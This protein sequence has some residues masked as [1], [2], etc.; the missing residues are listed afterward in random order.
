MLTQ[1]QSSKVVEFA[2]CRQFRVRKWEVLERLA[3]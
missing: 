2:S 1:L 3:A